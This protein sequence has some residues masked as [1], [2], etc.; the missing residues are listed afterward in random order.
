V[1][2]IHFNS[3]QLFAFSLLAT[4]HGAAFLFGW[5]AFTSAQEA[6]PEWLRD[7]YAAYWLV[8]GLWGM[9][10]ATHLRLHPHRRTARPLIAL[11]FFVW[12]TIYVV[13]WLSLGSR[14]AW[15]S[16]LIYLLVAWA[17]ADPP[18]PWGFRRGRFFVPHA[19][20]KGGD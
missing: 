18:S 1:N 17:V 8:T 4:I 7:I 14:N 3:R 13:G 2:N 19:P 20:R 10:C 6:L 11:A 16:A 5:V 9:L 15:F 12:A